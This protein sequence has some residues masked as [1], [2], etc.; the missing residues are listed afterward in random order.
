MSIKKVFG[1]LCFCL[2]L[3]TARGQ[4]TVSYER[5]IRPMLAK[6]CFECHNT[7]NPK[8]GV[9]LDNYKE[10]ARVIKDGQLW[11]KVMDQIKTRQMPPKGEPRRR[12]VNKKYADRI[13]QQNSGQPAEG[14][15]PTA[16]VTHVRI[17]QGE[18]P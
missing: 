9:N 14:M 17:L 8:G 2:M 4:D 16:I 18:F 11:L 10:E 13:F 15:S 5:D 1:L 6:K 12:I 3:S 7:G